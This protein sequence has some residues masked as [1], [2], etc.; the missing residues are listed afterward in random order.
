MITIFPLHPIMRILF[1]DCNKVGSKC[2]NWGKSW[3]EK[4]ETES[5]QKKPSQTGKKL[6]QTKLNRNWSVWIDFYSKITEPKQIGLNWFRFGFGFFILKKNQFGY[7]FKN[8]NRTEPNKKW[9][10][11]LKSTKGWL[12]PKPLLTLETNVDPISILFSI[13]YIWCLSMQYCHIKTQSIY[14]MSFFFNS[15][16]N[17]ILQSEL[18]INIVGWIALFY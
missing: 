17:I 16:I 14:L 11:L 5:K 18:S 12:D 7:F 4:S 3:L 6:S 2:Y 13:P 9:S 1:S 8:K 15:I 10:S